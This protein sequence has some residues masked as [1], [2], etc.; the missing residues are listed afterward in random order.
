MK[1]YP[2]IPDDLAVWAARQPFFLTASAPTHARHVNV[3]P[4]GLTSSHL[5]FLSPNEVAYV[6]RSGSG[7]ETIAHSYEN[8]R[9]TLMFMSFGPS[10][11]ILRLFCRSRVVEADDAEFGSWMR[12]VVGAHWHGEEGKEMEGAR[13]VIVCQ[14]WEVQT[15]C[16]FGVPMIKEEMYA[17]AEDIPPHP[18]TAAPASTEGGGEE[19]EGNDG[20]FPELK[21]AAAPLAEQH[22]S[23]RERKGN[24]LCV[25][26]DRPTLDQHWRKKAAVSGQVAAYQVKTNTTSIDG[27]P[28]LRMARKAA[29]ETLWIT[30]LKAR[31]RRALAE[32]DGFLLGITAAVFL[33]GITTRGAKFLGSA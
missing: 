22:P 23:A 8:G 4:K 15:S 20:P 18:L 12:R 10:P 3:S 29:A 14:V 30:D 27:L 25:F 5:A 7:C 21:H 6:D 28:G 24:E 2:S 26:E 9:L 33:Y 32:T 11:R 13:A 17:P 1:L 16:G 19:R 31:C